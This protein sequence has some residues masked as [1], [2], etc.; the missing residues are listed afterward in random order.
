MSARKGKRKPARKP[1]QRGRTATRARVRA[2]DLDAIVVEISRLMLDGGWTPERRFALAKRE[3][4]QPATVDEWSAESG[5]LLRVGPDVE[6]M[7]TINLVR[8]NETYARAE[9]AKGAVAAIAEQNRML[10]LHAPA[11]VAVTVQP[12]EKLTRAELRAELVTRRDECIRAIEMIDA[13]DGIV[14]VPALPAEGASDA[15]R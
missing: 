14:E 6:A 3:N 1:K 7:R 2:R 13:E 8:L 4:V 12:Y 10:G 9:D 15:E 5:R 11:R